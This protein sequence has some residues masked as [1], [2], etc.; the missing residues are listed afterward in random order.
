MNEEPMTAQAG[1]RQSLESRVRVRHEAYGCNEREFHSS[2]Q[3]G[4]VPLERSGQERFPDGE[5][6][7]P[8]R[9]GE[10][11]LGHQDARLGKATIW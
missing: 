4:D 6:A 1:S 10:M 11:E 8:K 5:R 2:F 3:V 9:S 7:A